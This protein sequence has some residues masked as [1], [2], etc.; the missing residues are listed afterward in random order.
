MFADHVD[1]I[2]QATFECRELFIPPGIQVSI[3]FE[4]LSHERERTPETPQENIACYKPAEVRRTQEP[5]Q[6]SRYQD[7]CA[8]EHQ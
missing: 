7:E 3:R 5:D 2:S 8:R 4:L 6:Q 1:E